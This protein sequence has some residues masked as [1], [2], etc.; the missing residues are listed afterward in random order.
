MAA[1]ENLL[2]LRMMSWRNAPL[3]IKKAIEWV[4]T[5][6]ALEMEPMGLKFESIPDHRPSKIQITLKGKERF[7]MEYIPPESW[8]AQLT[9]ACWLYSV[10]G[11]SSLDNRAN[12]LCTNS[13]SRGDLQNSISTKHPKS[14]LQRKYDAI[15]SNQDLIEEYRREVI[16]ESQLPEEFTPV[17]KE[18]VE[19]SVEGMVSKANV[20]AIKKSQ[21]LGD[22]ELYNEWKAMELISGIDSSIIPTEVGFKSFSI[23]QVIELLESE[24]VAPLLKEEIKVLEEE[25]SHLRKEI[26]Q[27]RNR[28]LWERIF[29]R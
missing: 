19:R 16:N 1:I 27:M 11:Y 5:K 3:V 24:G 7:Q 21:D 26:R 25:K 8:D 9:L 20:E 28:S 22:I 18:L 17:Q 14:K 13:R 23:H 6:H 10:R 15:L 12:I 2:D 4:E 29:N